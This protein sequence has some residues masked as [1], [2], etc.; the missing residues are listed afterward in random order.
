[1]FQIRF[2]SI[3]LLIKSNSQSVLSRDKSNSVLDLRIT[4]V[5]MTWPTAVS[6]VGLLFSI[7]SILRLQRALIVFSLIIDV[8]LLCSRC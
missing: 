2:Q 6:A 8:M 1:M 3:S 5:S 4:A 7:R